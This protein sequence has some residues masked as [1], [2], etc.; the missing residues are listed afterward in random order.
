MV[1]WVGQLTRREEISVWMVRVSRM[2][3]LPT[4]E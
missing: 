2:C 4:G 1:D 3:L